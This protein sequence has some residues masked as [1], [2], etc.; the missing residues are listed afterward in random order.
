MKDFIKKADSI[1][2]ARQT[3]LNDY[4]KFRKETTTTV[5]ELVPSFGK[6]G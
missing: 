1:T 4:N 6:E 3:I 5:P 2:I